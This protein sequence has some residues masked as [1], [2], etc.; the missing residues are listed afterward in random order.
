[1]IVDVRTTSTGWDTS[2]K[3]L[4]EAFH[5]RAQ[6]RSGAVSPLDGVTVRL[7]ALGLTDANRDTGTPPAGGVVPVWLYGATALVGPRW[8]GPATDA[9]AA[10]DTDGG[11][12]VG[13][14]G[15]CPLCVQRRW[16]AIRL[17]EERH[18]LEH[19]AKVSVPGPLPHL[20]PF[21]VEAIWQ[22]L[23]HAAAPPATR[24]GLGRLHQLRMDTL[25]TTTVEVLADSECPACATVRPDTAEGAVIALAPRPKPGPTTYRL[26]PA[27]ELDLPVVALANPVA[28]AL[29]GNALRAYNAN[30]TAP[31]S[32]YFRVRS[33]Y[34]LHEMWWSGHANSYGTSETY[35]LL[36][37]LERYAG[38]FPRAKR[39]E[40]YDSYANLAPDAM[41]PAGLGYDPAFYPGH[42]LYY[43]PYSPTEPMHWVWGYSLR[44]RQPR[45]VPE[46][47][48]YYLDR[49]EKQRKFV[50]ECSNGCASGS[51]PE[52]ALLHG[53]LE[54][55]ERDA[56]LLAWY[57]SSRLAEIDPATCRD[58]KV[59]FM[60]D[61]VELLGY[62]IRLFDTRADLPVPVVTAVAV[63]RGDGLGQ[64]CF[65]AG[66]SLDPDDAVRAAVCETASY[67]P[68]FD[69]RVEASLPALK[70]MTRDYTKVTELSHHALLY[71]LPEMT[72]HAQF[73]F[74]DPPKRSMDELYGDWLAAR[75]DNDDLTADTGYLAGLIAGLGG[76]VLAVD[77]TCPEQ[78]IAGVHT[79]ALVA[80]ALLPIDFG[81]QRQ[82]VLHSDRLARHLARGR[83]GPDQLGATA[84]NPHPHPFP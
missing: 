12:P 15:P 61:R 22:L 32:G 82:R 13:R 60:L 1:M 16:Q 64:L 62:D 79:M 76:D 6:R 36:E 63:K 78:E 26:R 28:G 17:R 58:E 46:Q 29:G 55:V 31:V 81:W 44:D 2:L 24:P 74:D 67:V 30:S 65:A 35:A 20:T 40:V 71:G 59:H 14:T 52:E 27:D 57:G 84:R 69:E 70:E 80:P 75:P 5:E 68:G 38:Q 19:G 53:M 50:Q 9:D 72:R 48:V 42:G 18:A 37:G 10:D 7:A 23:T 39:T 83:Q 56:F 73:L 43:A 21:A 41:D 11:A 34:D 47:L 25:E 45:L 66:A 51:S 54:L 77:Q 3:Q 33:R 8:P 49:R 4:G